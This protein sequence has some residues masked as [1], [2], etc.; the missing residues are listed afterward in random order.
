MSNPVR[1]HRRGAEWRRLT[2][3]LYRSSRPARSLAHD[4]DAWRLL[5]PAGAAFTHLTA[6]ELGGWWMPGQVRRPVF[7]ALPEDGPYP[8]RPG[9]IVSRHREALPMTEIDGLPVTTA[10]ET[11]LAACRDLGLLDLA[12]LGDSALRLGQLTLTELEET[13]MLRR[14]GVRRLRHLVPLLDKRSQS[15]W[16]SIMRVLHE[17]ADIPVEPQM[18]IMDAFGRVIAHADLGIV[19][20]NRI[21]EYDGDV[22]RERSVHR[23]D[24]ARDRVIAEQGTLRFGYTSVELRNDGASI[25]AAADRVLGRSWDPRR[26]QR[27]NALIDDS[28]L[29]LTGRRRVHQR[30]SGG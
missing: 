2:Y 15:P 12:V 5:L 7:V 23:S 25:I 14:R 29:G 3:G 19:G 13:A 1:G 27:W 28:L 9:L 21:H 20:T 11:L 8:R 17:A 4:L 22:H 26:L 16:E 6:A 30:W 24:L 10:A 18:E